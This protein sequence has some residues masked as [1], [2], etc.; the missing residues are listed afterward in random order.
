VSWSD[1]GAKLREQINQWSRWDSLRKLGSSPLVRSSL[2]FAIAG[3]LLLW[4]AKFQDFL[5]IRFDAHFSLWRIW[6][7]YY[8]GISVAI[9]TGLYS[10]FC[11][12]PI[13]EHGSA[14]ELAYSECQHLTIMGTGLRYLGD[15]KELEENCTHVERRLWPPD[16]PADSLV[17]QIRGKQH[18]P[19]VLAALII[20][21]W[22]VHNIK[23]P[24]LRAAIL[25]IYGSGFVLLGIPAAVTFLQVTIFAFRYLFGL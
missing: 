20:Y 13:K 19:E 11:P 12:R 14:F 24:R 16:R 21:A 15:V 6:M 18:E 3:Y 1:I 10:C 25:L 9:A 23:R 2:A 4:N 5:T 8:G 17:A 7:I 22:R